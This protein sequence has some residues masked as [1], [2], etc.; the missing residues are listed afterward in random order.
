[1]GLVTFQIGENLLVVPL[2]LACVILCGVMGVLI[3]LSAVV[4]Y[5]VVISVVMQ[6]LSN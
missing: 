4:A 3:F 6:Q 2:E 1:M 5:V